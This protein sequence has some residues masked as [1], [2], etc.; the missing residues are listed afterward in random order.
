MFKATVRCNP[1]RLLGHK[2]TLYI[3]ERHN[4]RAWI[5]KNKPDYW[6]KVD[7]SRS[8]LNL[9]LIPLVNSTYEELAFRYI[10]ERG[11]DITSHKS[12]KRSDRGYA[13]EYVIGVTAGF[14]YNGD[15]NRFYRKVHEWFINYHPECP[16]LHS[17]IHHDEA[18]P[19][20]HIIVVPIVNGRLNAS[21]VLAFKDSGIRDES[22]YNYMTPE[23]NLTYPKYL[24]GADKKVGVE[25]AIER[26]HEVIGS[27]IDSV[28][29][30]PVIQSIHARPEPF[31]R[32]AGVT[33]QQ[34]VD[35]RRSAV[36][37]NFNIKSS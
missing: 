3:A 12:F 9:E 16:I 30:Q 5:D 28:W 37:G 4:T 25:I 10:K 26:F 36:K 31:L 7:P 20:L 14:D 33:L 27:K 35:V 18:D 17:V 32:A 2:K 8:H 1:L 24:R 13:L 23:Y 29:H 34:I 15:P 21:K 6:G 22:L 19:H 11:I